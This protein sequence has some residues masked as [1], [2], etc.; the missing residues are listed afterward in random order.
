MIWK[1]IVC[2]VLGY[3]CGNFATGVIVSK[4]M[5][6]IDIRKK[7][8]NS[9]GTTNV[10]RTL[11]WLPSVLTLLGD[12]LKGFIPTLF[13]LWLA[14]RTGAYVAGIAVIAG[15]NWPALYGFKGGKG[16][17]TSL[18]VIFVIEPFFALALIACQ[19]IVLTVTKYMSI[20]SIASA[21]LYAVLTAVI[22]FGNWGE[23][24]FA[25]IVT[26]LALFSHR[27]NI[28]R[29]IGHKENRL[30][31]EKINKISKQPI[32]KGKEQ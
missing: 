13:A 7:G 25:L 8:S 24:I 19:A 31:F 4:Q 32:R 11:G 1:L 9:T 26:G 27:S 16:I 5:A 6:G 23:V 14:G 2:A 28:G 18:G 17:A 15:H 12:A 29:L 10:L 30:D 3:L 21:I 22:R 20:A